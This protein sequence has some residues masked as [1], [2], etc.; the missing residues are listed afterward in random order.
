MAFFL[1]FFISN[2]VDDI[3]ITAIQPAHCNKVDDYVDLLSNLES[4]TYIHVTV[5]I[6]L[7][8]ELNRF[9]LQECLG[10]TRSIW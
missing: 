9:K 1:F 8:L 5:V 6:S 3:N 4:A 10:I 7:D 2:L